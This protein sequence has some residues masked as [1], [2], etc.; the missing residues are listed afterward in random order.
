[1]AMIG[2]RGRALGAL[3]LA[4]AMGSI[5]APASAIPPPVFRPTGIVIRHKD[6]HVAADAVKAATATCP[7]GDRV[8]N[9]GGYWLN[10]NTL[11]SGHAW[12][13]SSFPT[14]DLTGWTASGARTGPGAGD[15][16]VLVTCA[17]S[18]SLPKYTVVKRRVD[19]PDRSEEEQVAA[20]CPANTE[21]VTGGTVFEPLGST[22]RKPQLAGITT[23]SGALNGAIGWIGLGRN[24]GGMVA[25]GKPMRLEVMAVCAKTAKVGTYSAI[26][27]DFPAG[28]GVGGTAS[29]PLN[30]RVIAGIAYWHATGNGNT[31]PSLPGEL[32]DSRP[33][34]D[35]SGWTAHGDAPEGDTQLS[36]IA[37]CLRT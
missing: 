7:H 12:I 10:G 15:F 6:V 1:M 29:C 28:N 19:I 9:G 34:T 35:G 31:D 25:T 16:R 22:T 21:I 26:G 24:I 17:A 20:Y 23:G 36:V 33:K 2:I 4:A 30:Y 11:S 14:A 8:I 13:G 18:T 5:G 32:V 3:V 37:Y 27:H